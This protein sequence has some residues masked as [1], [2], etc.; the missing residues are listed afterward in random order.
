MVRSVRRQLRFLRV[1]AIVNSLVLVVLATAAFRQ[2]GP[3]KFDRDHRAAHQHRRR[4]R[5][6][7]HGDL[8]QG[9][10]ASRA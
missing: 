8:E 9:P 3:Q 6:A 5:H 2:A 10:D 4:R 1:Y 7:A